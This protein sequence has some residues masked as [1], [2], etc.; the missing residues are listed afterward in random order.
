[1]A[2]LFELGCEASLTRRTVPRDSYNCRRSRKLLLEVGKCTAVSDLKP[3]KQR[4]SP[5]R[6]MFLE[7]IWRTSRCD[8]W[9]SVYA[10]LGIIGFS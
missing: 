10:W 6:V 5:L 9:S 1:M 3:P 2:L 4:Q 7:H 8:R